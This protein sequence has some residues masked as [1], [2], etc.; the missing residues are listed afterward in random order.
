[1]NPSSDSGASAQPQ[2]QESA[3]GTTGPMPTESNTR[4]GD[5]AGI[6]DAKYNLLSLGYLAYLS[7]NGPD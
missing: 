2:K 5:T 3:E 6:G 7:T 4:D 1:M